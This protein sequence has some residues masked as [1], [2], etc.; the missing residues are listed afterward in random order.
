MATT[1]QAWDAVELYRPIAT[2][3]E[4]LGVG[5]STDAR[6]PDPTAPRLPHS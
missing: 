2:Q 4:A 1:T 6:T 5:A 3:W